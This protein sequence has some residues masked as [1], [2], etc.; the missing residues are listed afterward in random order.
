MQLREVL[1]HLEESPIY[2]PSY[3][4]AGLPVLMF[5]T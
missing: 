3:A 4:A 2:I 1:L 5:N